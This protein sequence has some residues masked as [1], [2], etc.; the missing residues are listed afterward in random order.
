MK[1]SLRAF[2]VSAALGL[3]GTAASAQVINVCVENSGTFRYAS[4]AGCKRNEVPLSWNQSGPQGPAGPQ[5]PQ[6]P[7]GVPGPQ[8]PQGAPGPQGAMGLPGATGPSGPAGP[9]GDSTVLAMY[10]S[11]D[12]RVGVTV[13][14][15]PVTLC[16]VT[17]TPTG[18]KVQAVAAAN[19]N[20]L[21]PFPTAD[22]W[23]YTDIRSDE[24]V[25]VMF[26]RHVTRE[27]A[28]FTTH[29]LQA[30]AVFPAGAPTTIRV[31]AHAGDVAHVSGNQGSC[32][33]TVIEYSN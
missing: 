27:G 24:S 25:P 32:K 30:W 5:G 17:F 22:L 20:H 10:T 14:K 16:S 11:T 23:V 29:H 3:T 18:G 7:A 21:D 33:L 15:E 6:G 4:T 13:T 31:V 1:R 19:Y 28:L 9:K 8:G 26:E 12:G 2:V